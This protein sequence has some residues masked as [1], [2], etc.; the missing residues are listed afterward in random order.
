MATSVESVR[1]SSPVVGQGSDMMEKQQ[2][3]EQVSPTLQDSETIA[4]SELPA[5]AAAAATPPPPP[6]GGLMAW[7]QVLGAFFL[8]FNSWGIVNSFGSFQAHY[9]QVLIPDKSPSAI[10]WIGSFQGFL[11]FI[12]SV[13]VGPIFDK[14]YLKT[15]IVIGLFLVVFGLMMT[16]LST[17][18]YQL[19]L[20]Q[21]VVTG[22]GLAFNVLPS[23]AI[24]ATYFS[25][26]RALAV[27]ITASGGSIGSVLYPIMLR[28]TI[29]P[30]GFGWATRLMAFI[31]LG[32]LLI[33]LAV[34]RSRLPPPTKF[35]ALYDM[36]MFREPPSVAMC[37]A[38]VFCFL[39]IY[40]PLF[41]LP[42][43]YAV[44]LQEPGDMSFYVLSILNATSLIGR[45]GAGAIGD[46]IGPINTVLPFSFA[47]AVVAF[48]WMGIHNVGGTIVFAVIYGITS[49]AMVSV[50][51]TL[52]AALSPSLSV[53]GTRMGMNFI[54]AGVGLL[55][56][57]PIAGALI[58][59]E[60]RVFWKAQLFSAVTLVVS[61]L[62][63]VVIRITRGREL[64]GWKM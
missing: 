15:I 45:L 61:F 63:I 31:A 44:K 62:G 57:N 18:Y 24:I 5:P 16:S 46:N 43:F 20:A 22:C 30:L 4:S 51:L 29:G 36:T 54:F 35:R 10:S 48:A 55:I 53:V 34:M 47:S 9:E 23:V 39:G 42:T 52:V 12:V 40:F 3:G 38:M 32:T 19:F 14:G 6:D 8:F 2:K 33:P 28:K 58:D 64:T 27:G 13:F 1:T 37:F 60:N 59:L 25:K 21:G 49:G 17:Q 56:G 26:R 11:L 41:Y 50:S 7:L